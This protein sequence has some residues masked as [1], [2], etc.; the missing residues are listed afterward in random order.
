MEGWEGCGEDDFP[1]LKQASKSNGG[2]SSKNLMALA[3]TLSLEDLIAKCSMDIFNLQEDYKVTKDRMKVMEERE[4]AME[5]KKGVGEFLL[6]WSSQNVQVV[7]EEIFKWSCEKRFV[8]DE[9]AKQ[10]LRYQLQ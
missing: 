8:K 4:K 1:K 5:E 10:K 3:S 6:F 9:D 7:V 2:M